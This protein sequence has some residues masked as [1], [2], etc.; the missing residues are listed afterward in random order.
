MTSWKIA[1]EFVNMGVNISPS[2]AHQSLRSVVEEARCHGDILKRF[3]GA[4]SFDMFLR[5]VEKKRVRV[6]LGE[7]IT[8]S[9]MFTSA[10]GTGVP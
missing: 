8:V 5:S 6:P 4:T 10:M 7:S 9:E 1:H 2:Y 3:V